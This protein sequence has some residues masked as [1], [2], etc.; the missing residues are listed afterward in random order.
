MCGIVRVILNIID[1]DPIE[2]FIDWGPALPMVL[3]YIHTEKKEYRVEGIEIEP[4]DPKF[5]YTIKKIK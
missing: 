2:P 3:A 4:Q 1:N 5:K